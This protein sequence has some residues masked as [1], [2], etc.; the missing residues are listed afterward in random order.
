MN[1]LLTTTRQRPTSKPNAI[2]LRRS[3]GKVAI[4]AAKPDRHPQNGDYLVKGE[5]KRAYDLVQEG[6]RILPE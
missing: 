4:D 3:N 6:W 2:K 1:N 5:L